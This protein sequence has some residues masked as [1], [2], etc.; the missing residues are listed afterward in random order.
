MKR[1]SSELTLQ[2]PSEETRHFSR[3]PLASLLTPAP[4]P[5]F[6]GG[7]QLLWSVIRNKMRTLKVQRNENGRIFLTKT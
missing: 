3:T 2:R 6:L 7:E 5:L 4:P 1:A